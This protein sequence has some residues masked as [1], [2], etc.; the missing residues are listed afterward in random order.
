MF[1]ASVIFPLVPPPAGKAKENDNSTGSD[2]WDK[3]RKEL[4][5]PRE[6]DLDQFEQ[7]ATTASYLGPATHGGSAFFRGGSYPGR[8]PVA[9][10]AR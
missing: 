8:Y 10:A 9:P 1:T 5:G 4:Y 2:E 7:K 3:A 6:M